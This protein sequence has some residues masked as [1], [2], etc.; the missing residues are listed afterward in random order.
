M[1]IRR[2]IEAHVKLVLD[3]YYPS[4]AATHVVVESLRLEDRPMPAIIVVSGNAVPAF[5]NLTDS[6]GNWEVPLTIMVMS[7]L[8]DTTVDIHAEVAHQVPRILQQPSARKTS[9]IQGLYLYN[10]IPTS[11]GQENEGRRMIT[12]INFET[13][14]NYIPE[15]PLP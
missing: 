8:D 3:A 6:L 13:V 4:V 15:A 1:S 12:A 9:K 10:I 2:A 14:V 7:S 11:T 5:S